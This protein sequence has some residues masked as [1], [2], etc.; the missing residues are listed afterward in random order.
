[1]VSYAPFLIAWAGERTVAE[2]VT[3]ANAAAAL[4]AAE[5]AA[6]AIHQA[7]SL[8]SRDGAVDST[9]VRA[10]TGTGRIYSTP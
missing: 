9:R 7:G 1:M 8:P 2:A 3:A 4:D 5:N 10:G 6:R